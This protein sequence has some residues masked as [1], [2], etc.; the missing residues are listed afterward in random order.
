MTLMKYIEKITCYFKHN[1][2]VEKVEELV[3]KNH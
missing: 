2:V 1:G 3:K